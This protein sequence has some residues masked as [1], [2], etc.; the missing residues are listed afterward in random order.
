MSWEGGLVEWGAYAAVSA[1]NEVVIKMVNFIV[2][3]CMFE[4]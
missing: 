2:G 1:A 3:V 4:L